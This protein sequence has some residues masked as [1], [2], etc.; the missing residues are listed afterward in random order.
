MLS[1]LMRNMLLYDLEKFHKQMKQRRRETISFFRSFGYSSFIVCLQGGLTPSV[2][3]FTG[4]STLG[5]AANNH[6]AR[7]VLRSH[8]QR[9][10]KMSFTSA[11]VS[12]SASCES[13]VLSNGMSMARSKVAS[14]T[15]SS[16]GTL[17]AGSGGDSITS[18]PTGHH[19]RGHLRG[20]QKGQ[21]R[22]Q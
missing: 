1:A 13:S 6:H 9:P 18:K 19:L 15:S 10:T 17:T 21:L 22:G 12:P 16:T 2:T 11:E 20:Q 7:T 4:R 14:S 8:Q 5:L 3:G